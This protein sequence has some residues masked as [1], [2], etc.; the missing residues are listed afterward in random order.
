MKVELLRR[1][2]KRYYRLLESYEF[3]CSITV[4][5]GFEWDGASSPSFCSLIIPKAHGTLE[6]SCLHDYLCGKAT[7][8]E[9]RQEADRFFMEELEAQGLSRTRSKF[10]YVGV[11]VGAFFGVGN[12]Y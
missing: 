11:R 3:A 5:A 10:G 8:K 12:N 1:G 7:S 4:P 9:L 6:A 2:N